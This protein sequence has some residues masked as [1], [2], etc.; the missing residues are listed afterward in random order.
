MYVQN[1]CQVTEDNTMSTRTQFKIYVVQVLKVVTW[2][3]LAPPPSCCALKSSRRPTLSPHPSLQPELGKTI[4][5]LS[6]LLSCVQCVQCRP[7]FWVLGSQIPQLLVCSRI[8]DH[9]DG[10][11]YFFYAQFGSSFFWFEMRDR[12][13]T[14]IHCLLFS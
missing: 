12:G 9:R 14:I 6:K 4:V 5:F 1:C 2:N 11:H 10:T 13:W 3:I 8:N 7:V